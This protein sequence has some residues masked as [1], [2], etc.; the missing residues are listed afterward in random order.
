MLDS[1]Y[2]LA[3][4]DRRFC[5]VRLLAAPPAGPAPPTNPAAVSNPEPDSPPTSRASRSA[6]TLGQIQ[7]R[8]SV[9]HHAPPAQPT[10][11]EEPV[12]NEEAE[13]EAEVVGESGA[14]RVPVSSGTVDSAGID[15]WE[16]I[17]V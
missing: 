13:T 8:G 1:R 10:L 14:R 4:P 6:L 7:F 5:S 17:F 9:P 2:P 16:D 3:R 12:D 15:G 11:Q